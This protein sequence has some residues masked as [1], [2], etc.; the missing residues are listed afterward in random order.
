LGERAAGALGERAAGALAATSRWNQAQLEQMVTRGAR[1][2][3]GPLRALLAAGVE[4]S[5]LERAAWSYRGI[6]CVELPPSIDRN[7]LSVLPAA[8]CRRVRAVAISAD[9]L[10]VVVAMADPADILAYDDL[11]R[12]LAP[13]RLRVVAAVPE[14]VAEVV[15]RYEA[16][17]RLGDDDGGARAEAS[18]TA[19]RIDPGT[20]GADGGA[21]GRLVTSVLAY[22]VDAGASD[23]HFE[24]GDGYLRVRLRIDGVLH[25]HLDQVQAQAPAVVNRVKVLANMD[26]GERRLPHD[27]RASLTVGG[28][29]IDARVSTLPTT[30]GEAAV[31][32]ILDRGAQASDLASLRLPAGVM[33]AYARM[34]R[35]SHG[36]V[37]VTGPT[38]SGKTT[39]LYAT[40]L[41]VAS[42]ERKA[43][44]VEDPVEYRFPHITQVQVNHRIGLDFAA[45]LRALLRSDPDIVLVGE[46]RDR[47]TA[48]TAV[49]AAVTGHLVF[50][51][52]HASSAVATPARLVDIGVEPFLVAQALRGVLSQRLVRRLCSECAE[53]ESATDS[54][55]ALGFDDWPAGLNP[56]EQ[57][58]HSRDGGCGRCARTGFRGRVVV[59]EA[60]PVDDELERALAARAPSEVITRLAVGAG[61]VPLR[62]AGL[63]LVA[64]GQ[65]TAAELARVTS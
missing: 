10:E 54:L 46:I 27:G 30:W 6:P 53:P 21:I 16:L 33:D 4:W 47:E 7:T 9:A 26:V 55:G 32:R 37:L 51:T 64:A 15:R 57:L 34:W 31:L 49:E 22:A 3:L 58:W 24:P 8:L 18:A 11:A 39:T 61:M 17:D 42:P 13:R 28:R 40:L 2:G 65:T 29:S 59:A 56:P 62:A 43:I 41:E 1:R 25:S 48:R 19:E 5:E 38:G 12:A 20:A 52:V 36:L 63:E 23:V 35:A 60:M 45:A 50:A 44:T 14:A